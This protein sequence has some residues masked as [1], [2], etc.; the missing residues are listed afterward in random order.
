VIQVGSQSSRRRHGVGAI[1]TYGV[2]RAGRAG[3]IAETL[4]AKSCRQ[5]DLIRYLAVENTIPRRHKR[6][7]VTRG[8]HPT[9]P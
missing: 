9:S 1:V 4:I 7:V 6:Q 3:G 5:V 8:L 2:G